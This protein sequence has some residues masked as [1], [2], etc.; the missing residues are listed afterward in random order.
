MW[1]KNFE[2]RII[3]MLFLLLHILSIESSPK[4]LQASEE[5]SI[6]LDGEGVV[7]TAGN[8]LAVNA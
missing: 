3:E 7:G 6:L 1:S 8:P 5:L 2:L 4:E